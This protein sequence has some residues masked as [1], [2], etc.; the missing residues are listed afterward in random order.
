VPCL[1]F[2]GSQRRV[3]FSS[4]LK[5]ADSQRMTISQVY[6]DVE[7]GASEEERLLNE[8]SDTTNT[9]TY[10]L[11]LL[12]SLNVLALVCACVYWRGNSVATHA[13][14]NAW[15]PTRTAQHGDGII[16]EIYNDAKT[17]ELL[18]ENGHDW[19]AIDYLLGVRGKLDAVDDGAQLGKR[20]SALAVD[21]L[22][23]RAQKFD[24]NE[25]GSLNLAEFMKWWPDS[26]KA[27]VQN[28]FDVVDK[29]VK[30]NHEVSKSELVAV[31]KREDGMW[32][33]V[34]KDRL[35]LVNQLLASR[36]MKDNDAD[37]FLKMLRERF[38]TDDI[39]AFEDAVAMRKGLKCSSATRLL[40]YQ[41][42]LE[43]DKAVLLQAL[44][45]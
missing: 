38:T 42:A 1:S 24:R 45:S 2:S 4:M 40:F 14:G 3:L 9:R 20:R 36:E 7:E 8:Q 15:I 17:G 5:L 13:V 31:F 35:A 26:E 28:S 39:K 22:K 23:K 44:H 12:V 19:L 29:Q 32:T 27:Q 18:M 33:F 21:W 41:D 10:G 16:S 11:R 25:D 37:G 43:Q 30:S 34:L 6:L